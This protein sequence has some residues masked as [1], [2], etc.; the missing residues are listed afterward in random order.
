LESIHEAKTF[1]STIA[2]AIV[3]LAAMALP[4]INVPSILA[5]SSGDGPVVMEFDTNGNGKIDR[6]DID[7]DGDGN[8]DERRL[9]LDENGFAETVLWDGNDDGVFDRGHLDE[10]RDGQYDTLWI[11]F[12]MSGGI[13]DLELEPLSPPDLPFWISNSDLN[14]IPSIHR[15]DTNG[16]GIP[17][18][19][20]YDAE[21]N[22]RA[23]ARFEDMNP[24]DTSPETVLLNNNDD[25]KFDI[26]LLDTD[27]DKKH[28]RFWRDGGNR[29]GQIQRRELSRYSNPCA[30]TPT[31]WACW[32]ARQD[33]QNALNGSVPNIVFSGVMDVDPKSHYTSADRSGCTLHSDGRMCRVPNPPQ[34]LARLFDPLLELSP[35][36]TERI[37]GDVFPCGDGPAGFT[38]C[39][40][41]RPAPAG[42]YVFLIAEFKDNIFLSDETR[43]YQY[44]FVF[45]ADGRANNN[46]QPDPAFPN[47]FFAFTDKWYELNY[48]PQTG[49]QVRVRDVRRGL[50]QVLS[51]ARFV[52]AGREL[53]VFIPLGEFNT[54][55]PTFRATAFC[56]TGDFGLQGGPWSGDYFPLVGDPLLPVAMSDSV[57]VIDK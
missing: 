1:L 4:G 39:A 56:H 5:V 44:A 31:P 49:W 54:G 6:V 52:I 23:D 22:G 57:I 13:G 33:L 41:S 37:F 35:V 9:D 21:N 30:S 47:D 46:F 12:D 48:S 15:Q 38:I 3:L 25:D 18:I 16:N 32:S 24:E 45:D 11:D 19:I 55:L 8:I 14:G 26:G 50:A 27:G 17:D 43:L 10:D 28:D 40:S 42:C 34:D 36:A 7:L 20:T 51:D 29:D 53:A 2:A